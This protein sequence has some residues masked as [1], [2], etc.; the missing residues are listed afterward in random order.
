MELVIA[1]VGRGRSRIPRK[2]PFIW[3]FRLP[4]GD[5]DNGSLPWATL[6]RNAEGR[7]GWVA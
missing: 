1:S 6:D 4:S 2:T 7:D 3:I 5:R